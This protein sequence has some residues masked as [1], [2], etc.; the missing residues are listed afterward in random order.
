MKKFV[1]LL[2]MA[3][4]LL[5]AA[6]GKQPQSPTVPT[7][8]SEPA[9]QAPTQAPT[10]AVT[11]PV[12]EPPTEPATEPATEA[13]TEPITEPQ[14]PT[15][16]EPEGFVS[17]SVLQEAAPELLK[18]ADLVPLEGDIVALHGFEESGVSILIYDQANGTVLSRLEVESYD[19]TNTLESWE[20]GLLHYDGQYYWKITV[21]ENWQL[22]RE[23]VDVRTL[24]Y[25]MGSHTVSE[26]DG[27]ILLD[28]K[29]VPALQQN[30]RAA[31]SFVRV[32]ND[33]QLL[34]YVTDRS[35]SSLSHYSVYDHN[36]GEI[37]AVTTMGQRVIGNWGDLLLVGYNGSNGRYDFGTVSLKD[38]TYTPLEIGHETEE[39]G[40]SSDHYEPNYIQCST[41]TSQLMLVWDKDGT[42]TVQIVDMETGSELYRWECPHEDRYQFYLAD[43]NSLIVR[44]EMESDSILWT[45][46][47]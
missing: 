6:C 37:R 43:N 23:K 47:Y 20:D 36:T 25:Q 44:R 14:P 1:V 41:E 19:G 40:I 42:R 34:C 8:P 33:R 30:D 39:T 28:G 35:I 22:T 17:V 2:M 11:E 4:L 46:E 26:K 13:P 10:E 16:V 7:E 21:E 12:T 3:A 18:A 38:Y 5:S 9:T 27:S 15:I 24:Y 45:V 31:Y 32:L 29:A